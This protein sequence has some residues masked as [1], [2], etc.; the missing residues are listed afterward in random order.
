MAEAIENCEQDM[1]RAM[2]G[3]EMASKGRSAAEQKATQF[4]KAAELA[5]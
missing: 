4:F 1:E 5:S 3:R 2:A